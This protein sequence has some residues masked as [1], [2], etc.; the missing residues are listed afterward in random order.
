MNRKDKSL[1]T[2]KLSAIL[3]DRRITRAQLARDTGVARA[4]LDRWYNDK[5]TSY[6]E[7]VLGALCQYLDVQPGDLLKLVEQG[8]LF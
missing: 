5:V 8:K 3:G 4:V 1:V 7:R 2:C 6:D